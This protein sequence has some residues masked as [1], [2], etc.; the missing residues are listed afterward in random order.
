MIISSLPPH[1]YN[2]NQDQNIPPG[3]QLSIAWARDSCHIEKFTD[4]SIVLFE[5]IGYDDYVK[6]GSYTAAKDKGLVS[7]FAV[8][9]G[10]F[11][12]NN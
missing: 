1:F 7:L 10:V 3:C 4:F 12:L 9:L 6:A 5:Q 11:G 2:R 8:K